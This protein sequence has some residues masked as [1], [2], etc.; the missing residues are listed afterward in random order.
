[1]QRPRAPRRWRCAPGFFS[2]SYP[3]LNSSR[4]GLLLGP[5]PVPEPPPL[6]DVQPGEHARHDVLLPGQN[7]GGLLRGRGDDVSDV[8]HLREGRRRR[9][10]YNRL[11]VRQGRIAPFQVQDFRFLCPNGTAFDQD[12]Q[13][14]AEW[15]DV[16]CD[17]STLYYSSDNF[18][19]Y[20]IGSGTRT[21]T[22]QLHL[23]LRG[24][25]HTLQEVDWHVMLNSLCRLPVT[26]T[27]FTFV[28][29]F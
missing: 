11:I 3:A 10:E 27:R 21:F 18:D 9:G 26:K 17:I 15:E 29:P 22:F 23:R 19:L 7:P 1:M 28:A 6:P 24:V 14:C 20:R 25:L 8:P 5:V 12:H 4:V 2:D 13:I 16:D